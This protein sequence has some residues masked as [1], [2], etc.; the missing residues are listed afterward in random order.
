MLSVKL[1]PSTTFHLQLET[2]RREF[3]RPSILPR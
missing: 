2:R 1:I 3:Q